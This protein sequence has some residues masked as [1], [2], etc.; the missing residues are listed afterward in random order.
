[1]SFLRKLNRLY[2]FFS[3]KAFLPGQV[4]QTLQSNL[5]TTVSSNSNNI[6]G[7]GSLPQITEGGQFCSLNFTPKVS[8]S[9]VLIIFQAN[10]DEYLNPTNTIYA[11]IF[12]STQNDVIFGR[13]HEMTNN[14]GTLAVWS[15]VFLYEHNEP[16]GVPF[17]FSMRVGITAGTAYQ[18]RGTGYHT[19]AIYGASEGMWFT[20]QEIAP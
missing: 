12:K 2:S 6:P 8:G 16:V 4:V 17:T 5:Y 14:L 1:M 20:V 18:N 9:S 7:D 13:S 11:G 19:S 10:G 15:G 3:S